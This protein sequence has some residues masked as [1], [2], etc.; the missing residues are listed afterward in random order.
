MSPVMH[1]PLTPEIFVPKLVSPFAGCCGGSVGNR[2][3]S[4]T[5]SIW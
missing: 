3:V 1:V 4:G 2:A 5:R